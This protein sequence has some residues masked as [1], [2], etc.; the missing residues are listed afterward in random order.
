VDISSDRARLHNLLKDLRVRWQ[1]VQEDWNDPVR[2]EFE[3][4]HWTEL[5][6]RVQAALQAMS[7]LAQVMTQVRHDCS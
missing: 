5:E 1:Q 7:R 3:E 2:R 4:N 6:A